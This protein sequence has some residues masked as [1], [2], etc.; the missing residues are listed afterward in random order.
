MAPQWSLD[1]L[2]YGWQVVCDYVWLRSWHLQDLEDSFPFSNHEK[3][4]LLSVSPMPQWEA[5]QHE[6]H[7]PSLRKNEAAE[8]SKHIGQEENR[9]E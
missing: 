8:N 6:D 7:D 4:L 5:K 2:N 9:E 3:V 1:N